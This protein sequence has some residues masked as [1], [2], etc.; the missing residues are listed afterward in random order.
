VAQTA[1][2]AVATLPVASRLLKGT[3]V[4]RWGHPA[5]C[6][7]GW[8]AFPTNV[9]ATREIGSQPPVSAMQ[10]LTV[11]HLGQDRKQK[12]GRVGAGT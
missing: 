9:G 7:L 6:M 11:L 4:T 5:F 1:V 2:G 12:C 3:C 10:A 8:A